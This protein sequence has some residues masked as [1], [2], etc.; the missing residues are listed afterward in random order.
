MSPASRSPAFPVAPRR[1]KTI[2]QHNRT[3]VDEYY[4]LR[5][6]EDPAVLDYIKAE[7]DYL[8]EV[9]QHTQGLQEQIFQEMKGR[10]K[11]DDSSAPERRGD[12]FYYTRTQAGQQ[13]PIFCRKRGSLDAPEEIVL[14]QN[15][16]A[17]GLPYF[18]VGT[19]TPSPDNA[20]LAYSVDIAG[21][22]VYTLYIKDLATGEL[23]P[24]RIGNTYANSWGHDGVEWANDSQTLFYLTLDATLRPC[25]LHSHVLG[26]PVESDLERYYEADPTFF[27]YLYKFR[28]NAYL[29]LVAHATTTSEWR[30]LPASRPNEPLQVFQARRH[31]TEYEVEH[32]GDRFYIVTNEEAL[33]F[34]LMETPADAIGRENWREVLPHR[35]DVLLESANAFEQYLVLVERA[36]SLRQLRVSPAGDLSRARYVEFPEPA[37]TLQLAD[38]HEYKSDCVR[39][40]YSSLITPN[41]VVDYHMPTGTSTLV[42]R[43]EIPSGHDPEQYVTERLQATAPDGVRVPIS[44][45]Y[46]KG[47]ALDGQN[48]AVMYGYGSYG[49]SFDAGFMAMRFSL[50]DRGFVV[51]VAHVRGGAE[52]G[53]GWYE[54]GRMRYKRNTFT[55]FIACAEHLIAHEYTSSSKLAISGVSAG[56][57]LVTAC[58][59]MRPELFAA[60]IARVPFVD[61]INTMSDP[62]IPLTTHEYEQWGH[63]DNPDDF[64]YMLSYSPYDN[65]RPN[66]YPHLLLTSGL[67]DPRVAYWEPVKFAARLR[68]LKTDDRRVL[69]K[70]NLEAGHGGASGRYD[71]LREY[72]LDYAFLID[73]L[74]GEAAQTRPS[75]P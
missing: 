40:Y 5:Y 15:A 33:N 54:A 16:L 20:R 42:K 51:A 64:E 59:T 44:V 48:P 27:L 63:P 52:L 39:F 58:M 29:A 47:L 73:C 13:Y 21:S 62:S 56:G 35:A 9:M 4:W 31:G 57:L 67:N 70:T 25:R 19:F 49:Y 6:R 61:V 68:A 45:V 17:E 41:S 34:R 30:L 36:H 14:D 37:Y 7:N 2:T 46:R 43:D 23:Y 3:R 28:S 18:K 24:E 8:A 22:E 69:L 10:I 50:I 66:A 26:T 55:D 71:Y 53:R 74:T 65:L 60:V 11:E 72:A 75:R 12:C 32:Q 1:P 38:N